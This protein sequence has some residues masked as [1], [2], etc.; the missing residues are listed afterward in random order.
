MTDL[1]FYVLQEKDIKQKMKDEMAKAMAP[2]E[3]APLS[4]S[5]HL[6]LIFK[7]KTEAEKS[8]AE[9]AE[10]MEIVPK[11]MIL[12][13]LILYCCLFLPSL[14]CFQLVNFCF[15]L[16]FLL[17]TILFYDFVKVS[18]LVVHVNNIICDDGLC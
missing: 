3:G 18:C 14:I 7:I 17:N 6:E 16:H 11:S 2:R 13:C 9:L 15:K 1:K 10:S 5:E 12:S 8:S 4:A